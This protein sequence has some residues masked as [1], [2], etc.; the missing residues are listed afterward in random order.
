MREGRC[1]TLGAH[2]RLQRIPG[3]TGAYSE[4]EGA[5]VCREAVARF[6]ARRDGAPCDPEDVFMTDGASPGVHYLMKA[7]LR[8]ARDCVLTP[9][10]Q[11]PLYS[12]TITLYGG[13]L[14]PYFLDEADGWALDTA[15]LG[16][17]VAAARSRG[18]AVRALCVINPGNPTGQCLS[19]R[20]QEEVVRL[21]AD[22]GIV[23][24]ADEV[25][26]DNV[27]AEGKRFTSFKRVAAEMGLLG[28]L[29]LVSFNSISKGAVGECGR[30]GGYFEITGVDSGVR[31]ALLKLASINL[32]PNL[33]GQICMALVCDPPVAG[34]PS[35]ARY[36]AERSAILA[37]L[38]RRA[39]TITV[40]LNALEG[41]ICNAAE[42]AMYV[43]PRL[44]LPP[45]AHAAAL[46]A[47][48]LPDLF[49]CW[50]LLDATGICV[51]P[52]SGFG[53]A[54]GTWHFRTT[55]LPP[56][57]QMEEVCA[58]ITTFHKQFMDEFR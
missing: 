27:Y 18:D 35:F 7:L 29:P 45:K 12:A 32:C 55:F 10:P 1:E 47:G 34:E 42:G 2:S 14:L 51:V 17:A 8:D 33:S 9:I 41:V 11:Y 36:D 6:V 53:Q 30:R 52:G 16:A 13:T 43:F 24:L 57:E 20:N 58:A 19:R 38:R 28:Q 26:Q 25:Y 40:A 49:Y 3:G 50:R 5:G 48:R 37:S 31:D 46:A 21:C 39:G 15:A 54:A 4:S 44:S 22:E 56:E 23:L